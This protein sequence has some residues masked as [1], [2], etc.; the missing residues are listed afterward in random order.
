[1]NHT[2][3]VSLNTDLRKVLCRVWQKCRHTEQ[4]WLLFILTENCNYVLELGKACNFSLVG[5]GGE[6]IHNGVSTL[7]LGMC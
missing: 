3:N 2:N 6:D 7:T 4:L 5:I 1:M